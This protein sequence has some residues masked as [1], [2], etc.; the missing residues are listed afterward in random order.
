LADRRQPRQLVG[1]VAR[2]DP[3]SRYHNDYARGAAAYHPRRANMPTKRERGY[4]VL[5]IRVSVFALMDTD[6]IN[7][8][9]RI[10]RI[11]E[12]VAVSAT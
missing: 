1:A 5:M 6:H 8:A 3:P 12:R 2:F 7:Q 11:L 9:N 10:G 4:A